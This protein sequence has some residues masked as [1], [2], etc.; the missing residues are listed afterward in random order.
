M[1][2]AAGPAAAQIDTGDGAFPAERFRLTMDH[3]GLLDVESARTP[4]NLVVDVG[5]WLGYASDPLT[6]RW[7]PDHEQLGS[8]VSSR[9]G[10]EL[11]GSVGI[12]DRIELG[13][14]A[15]VILSQGQDLGGLMTVD[16]LSGAGLGNLKLT[17]KFAL[18]TGNFDVAVALGLTVPTSTSDASYLGDSGLTAAPEVLVGR[19]AG[20]LRL[21]ANLGY[22]I[23]ENKDA[24]GL[25]VGDE[26]FTRLGAGYQVVEKVEALASLSL[27]TAA[28]SPFSDY[29]RNHAELHA[30]AGYQ[31][32]GTVR[33][34]AAG[35]LGLSSGFGTADWRGLAGVWVAARTA[36]EP[37]DRDHDRILDADDDCPDQPEN[38]NS[39]EDDDGCPDNPDSDGDGIADADDKCPKDAEDADGFQDDDGCPDLDNDEDGV[40]DANDGCPMEVGPAENRGCPDGDRDGDT[41]V[42]RLDNCPD[43]PG[44]VANHGC[45]ELVTLTATTIEPNEVI[46][47][48]TDR[49]SI[50]HRSYPLL[51]AVAA[52]INAHPEITRV[53]VEGHTD[54]QGGADYNK[55]LSQRRAQAVVDYLTRKG[56]DASKLTPVG[57]G[58]EQPVGD[59]G[60]EQ[61]RAANRRVVFK[62]EGIVMAPAGAGGDGSG[63]DGSGT[64]GDG[65]G[66]DDDLQ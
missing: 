53:V 16:S 62:I 46:Y 22:L 33:L 42:D 49:A 28:A 43:E 7:G 50:R 60:T 39:F 29:N 32:T 13:L 59:N 52:V 31:V 44:T 36:R 6:L 65:G 58:A 63:G 19:T 23:R 56:V 48:R 61:G 1:V 41:V 47:F 12:G 15:P 54:D 26:L 35:G 9:F 8:L 3:H 17:P 30:G 21:G 51:D 38:Y 34:F 66:G 37:S 40:T 5:L 2:A 14:S 11:V 45:K 57:Y 18:L 10:G 25:T 24:A 4:G 20:K 64:G 27:A 55:D